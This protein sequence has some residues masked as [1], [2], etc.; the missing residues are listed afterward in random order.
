MNS[1]QH[2]LTPSGAF[3]EIILNPESQTE[4]EDIFVDDPT[5]FTEADNEGKL[6][7]LPSAKTYRRKMEQMMRSLHQLTRE[8][9][10]APIKDALKYSGENIDKKINSLD[11][12]KVN[13]KMMH[14]L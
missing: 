10:I 1:P 4:I 9:D 13:T 8:G 3:N 12:N 7:N 11:E 6:R 2:N 5:T 14:F